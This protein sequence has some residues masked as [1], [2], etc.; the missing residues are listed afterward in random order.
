MAI[1]STQIN[2][3]FSCVMDICPSPRYYN[4]VRPLQF[5]SSSV[6]VSCS[7]ISCLKRSF[8][9]VGQQLNDCK[10]S[11]HCF[12]PLPAS[13][14]PFSANFWSSFPSVQSLEDEVKSLVTP[15]YK[16][17]GSFRPCLLQYQLIRAL[18]SL[19]WYLYKTVIRTL[20]SSERLRLLDMVSVGGSL[21]FGY[22]ICLLDKF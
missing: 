5:V 3:S 8:I 17:W 13:F 1:G 9:Y 7:K 16:R 11:S 4:E 15:N 20:N 21:R 19:H 22:P 10:W 14:Q 6:S 12:D 2:I 18:R